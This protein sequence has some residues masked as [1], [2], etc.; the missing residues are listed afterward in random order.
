[1]VLMDLQVVHLKDLLMVVVAILD[2]HFLINSKKNSQNPLN[3]KNIF[4]KT[5][6]E[7]IAD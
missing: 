7:Q 6:H 5:N 2:L 1:M 4:M 3:K